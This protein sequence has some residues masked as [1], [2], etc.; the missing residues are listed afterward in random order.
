MKR[1]IFKGGFG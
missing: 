1:V